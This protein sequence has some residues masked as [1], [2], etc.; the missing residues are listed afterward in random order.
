MLSEESELLMKWT[1]GKIAWSSPSF[2]MLLSL[3]KIALS[4]L[5]LN[6]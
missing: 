1:F 2:V 5:L 6:L 3:F 4:F